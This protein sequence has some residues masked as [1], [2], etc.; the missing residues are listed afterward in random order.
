MDMLR[1]L[2]LESA[3]KIGL[4]ASSTDVSEAR[5]YLASEFRH[6][7]DQDIAVLDAEVI[8]GFDMRDQIAVPCNRALAG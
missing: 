7:S 4:R 2:G 8:C 3:D 5:P 1:T 6:M